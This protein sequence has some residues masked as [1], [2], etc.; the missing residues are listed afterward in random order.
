MVA[1]EVCED[2]FHLGCL[3]VTAQDTKKVCSSARTQTTFLTRIQ[4]KEFVCPPCALED[5]KPYR[6][7]DKLPSKRSACVF[8][9]IE[10]SLSNQTKIPR[11]T[12]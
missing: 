6:F 11:S 9:R 3:N 7:R 2:W 10:H 4:V 8:D 5:K 12:S 1:C